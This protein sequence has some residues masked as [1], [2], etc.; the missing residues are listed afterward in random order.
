MSL[1]CA[2]PGALCVSVNVNG[3]GTPQKLGSLVSYLAK[4]R[5]QVAFVQETKTTRDA[6]SVCSMLPG[7][8]TLWPG[9]QFF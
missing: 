3:L 5:A 9:A 1:S 2:E 6:D 4:S 7:L 8:S